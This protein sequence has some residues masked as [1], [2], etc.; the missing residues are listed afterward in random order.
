[1]TQWDVGRG[2][3]LCPRFQFGSKGKSWLVARPVLRREQVLQRPIFYFRARHP[4]A[5]PSFNNNQFS[6]VYFPP[7]LLDFIPP[8][9]IE[10]SEK[11]LSMS[12]LLLRM[13]KGYSRSNVKISP[14]STFATRKIICSFFSSDSLL[15]LGAGHDLTTFEVMSVVSVCARPKF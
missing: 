4:M 9:R 10:L 2:A 3:K 1:M 15:S 6:F 7:T 5:F 12:I 14:K 13:E 11:V 8:P